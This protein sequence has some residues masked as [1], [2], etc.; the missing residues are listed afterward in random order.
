MRELSPDRPD[1][2]E[3]P[4]T[5]DAGWY[6]IEAD[7]FSYVHDESMENALVKKNVTL[8]RTLILKAGISSA[9][10]LEIALIPYVSSRTR[11]GSGPFVKSSGVGD[12]TFR[13]KVNL[14]G[15][16]G[17]GLALGLIPYYQMPTAKT[18]LG[19]GAGGG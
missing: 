8:K 1:K 18:G 13:L 2:T 19:S 11:E 3:S 16:D 4:Y 7:G 9:M 6:Q 15:N 10:D 14:F 17:K 12:T 5:V